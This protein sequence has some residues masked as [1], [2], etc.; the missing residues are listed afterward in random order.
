MN[1][2]IGLVV[3]RG[4]QQPAQAVELTQRLVGQPRDG[5]LLGVGRLRR[6]RVQRVRDVVIELERDPGLLLGL[7]EALEPVLQAAQLGPQIPQFLLGLAP[8]PHA[9]FVHDDVRPRLKVRIA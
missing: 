7:V 1:K 4:A 9:L 8:A 2:R 5:G 6:D 3:G